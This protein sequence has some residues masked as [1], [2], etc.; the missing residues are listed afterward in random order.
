[1]YVYIFI[2]TLSIDPWKDTQETNTSGC[3][4]RKK[5]VVWGTVLGK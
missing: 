1:M 4:W 3:Y 5:W 2:Q